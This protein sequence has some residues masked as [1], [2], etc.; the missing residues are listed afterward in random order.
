[1]RN[2]SSPK[3]CEVFLEPNR[4]LPRRHPKTEMSLDLV[5]QHPNLKKLVPPAWSVASR[6]LHQNSHHMLNERKSTPATLISEM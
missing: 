6:E 1:M 5:S 4:G 3:R 2:A